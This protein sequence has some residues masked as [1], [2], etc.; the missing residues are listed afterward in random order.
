M[1]RG[2]ENYRKGLEGLVQRIATGQLNDPWAANA[3]MEP[4][5]GDVR[6]MDKA[7]D[8]LIGAVDAQVQGRQAEIAAA[9]KRQ[10]ALGGG[11][12]V[13]AALLLTALAWAIGRAI[14]QPLAS[15]AAALERV[16]GGDLSQPIVA[17]GSDELAAMTRR[18][19]GMQDALREV[20]ASIQGSADSVATA[21]AQIAGGSSDLSSRSEQQAA[22]LQ[23][24]AASMSQLSDAVRSS[25][26]TARQ[27]D[28]LAGGASEVAR[29]GG[30]LVTQVVATMQDIQASSRRIADIIGTID[31]IAFQTNILALNAAV[32]AARAG[33][34]G[35]GFAVVASEVR[36]LAGRSAAAAREIK[37]LISVSVERVDSGSAIVDATG[38]TMADVVAQVQQ[39]T[40]LIAHLSA[41]AAE[42]SRGIAQIGAAVTQLDG[43]TQQNAA[44]VEESA[45]AADGLKAQAARLAQAAAVF[46]LA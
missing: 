7:L 23:Q 15:A 42:Q 40:D 2:L 10:L 36:S 1:Q 6:A 17:R 38:R 44:L 3:A 28:T 30:E 39:V 35:R 41:S 14:T 37:S 27:A 31:G 34:Q 4:L 25:A 8:E 33:E 13:V 9:T 21:S 19:A 32:E 24:T 16:A 12:F 11:G 45:A 43:T 46:R 18:L 20:A 29:R 22:S 26:E 5:K